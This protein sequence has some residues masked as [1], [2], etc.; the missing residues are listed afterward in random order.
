MYN[1]MVIFILGVK[2]VF[3]TVNSSARGKIRGHM[4]SSFTLFKKV[5]LNTIPA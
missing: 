1:F 4:V 2:N 5:S 3:V